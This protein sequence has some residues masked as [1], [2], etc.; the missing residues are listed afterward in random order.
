MIDQ[1]NLVRD[2]GVEAGKAAPPVLV[3]AYATMTGEALPV[4]V[5]VLTALYIILQAGFLVWK[6]IS[7][8]RDRKAAI[9]AH[10]PPSRYPQDE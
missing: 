3:S 1:H 7:A 8:W 4:I 2:L 6:W 10:V 5:G 9:E